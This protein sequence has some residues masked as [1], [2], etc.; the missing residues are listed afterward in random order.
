MSELELHPN[1]QR[2]A[3]HPYS[4][5]FGTQVALRFKIFTY[6]KM[7]ITKNNDQIWAPGTISNPQPSK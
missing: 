5:H 4:C 7:V 2:L 1:S 3:V 6:E